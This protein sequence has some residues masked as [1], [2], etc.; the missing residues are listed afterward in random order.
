M[1]ISIDRWTILIIETDFIY[2]DLVSRIRNHFRVIAISP[3]LFFI[4]FSSFSFTLAMFKT[5]NRSLGNVF[6]FRGITL[7][8]RLLKNV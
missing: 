5:P 6:Y 2:L 1:Q 8:D 4:L 7:Y 3:L